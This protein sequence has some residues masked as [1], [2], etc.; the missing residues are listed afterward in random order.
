MSYTNI[1]RDFARLVIITY[2]DEDKRPRTFTLDGEQFKYRN[3]KSSE[4][5]AWYENKDI[6][7]VGVH[8]ADDLKLNSIAIGQFNK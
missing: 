6:I 1:H 3:E 8:G 7:L 5:W 2:K 4:L